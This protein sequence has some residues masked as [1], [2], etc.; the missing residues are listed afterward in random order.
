LDHIANFLNFISSPQSFWFSDTSY[1]HGCHLA[2][3]FRLDPE[4]YTR[5]SLLPAWYRM[6]DSG[7]HIKADAWREFLGGRRFVF[8][9]C[10]IEFKQK[11]IELDAYINGTPPSRLKQKGFYVVRIGNKSEQSPNKIE[12]QNG[13][14]GRLNTPPPPRVNESE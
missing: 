4:E 2:S 3:R 14:D 10:A 1:K 8:D 13:R 5:I 7:F 11:K 6:Q 12:E 9:N